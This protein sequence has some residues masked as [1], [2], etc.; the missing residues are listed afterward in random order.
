M[1]ESHRMFICALCYKQ[2]PICT[3]CD[4]SNRYCSDEC[5]EAARNKAMKEAGARYQS[6]ERGRILHAA[7]QARYEERQVN[8][9]HQSSSQVGEALQVS[10]HA[11]DIDVAQEEVN[12]D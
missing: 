11:T 3:R 7:R 8:L 1:V 10:P 9:T 6:T 4:R 2:V 5:S 12:D